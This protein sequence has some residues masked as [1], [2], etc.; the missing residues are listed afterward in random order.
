VNPLVSPSRH[1]SFARER[2]QSLAPVIQ[3]ENS[4]RR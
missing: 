3:N 1:G 2:Y 4:D